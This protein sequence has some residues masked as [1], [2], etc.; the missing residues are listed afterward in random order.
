MLSSFFTVLNQVVVLFLL[1]GIGYA[2]SKTG[3]IDDRC[4][5]QMTSLLCY[6]ISPGVI[7]YAFQMK[8]SSGMFSNLLIVAAAAAGIN[9]IAV[10]AGQVVFNKKTVPDVY[11]RN[12]MRFVSVYSNCGFMGYP[13]LQALAGTTGLFYGSV[14]NGIFSLFAWTHG[15]ALYSGIVNK[16]SILKAVVNPN[17]IAL[18]IGVLLFRFSIT[19]PAPV[20]STVEYI[21]Q[22][23]TPLSMIIIGT[24]ITQIPPRKI[25]SGGFVWMGTL[26]RN[27]VFPFAALFLLHAVGIGGVPLLCC[28]V[29]TACPV[30]GLTVLFAKL[31]GKDV[32]FPGKLMTL[33]TIMSL[34]TIPV[35]VAAI[36][37]LNF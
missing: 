20:Y 24:T 5:T 8:F 32:V 1:M 9:I 12:V 19:L 13:L 2:L 22:L 28:T 7:I 31:T 16:K 15:M 30:A 25:F 14:F 33:S 27:L 11:K 17:I 36:S 10:A 34:I 37:I 35:V 29:L 6:V 23:N 3:M 18:F 4:S 26:I 21:S